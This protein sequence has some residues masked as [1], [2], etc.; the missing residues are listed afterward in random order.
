MTL[1]KTLATHDIVAAT[2]PRPATEADEVGKVEGRVIDSTLSQFNYESSQ[3]RKPTTSSM[4]RFAASFLTAELRVSEVELGPEAERAMLLRVSEVLKA[5]RRTDICGLPRPKTRM[6]LINQRIGVY[7]Q[8]DYWDAQGRF[9]EMKS[10]P[11]IPPPPDV[12]LQLAMF[13]LAFPGFLSFLICFDRH[14]T[15]VGVTLA[16]ITPPSTEQVQSQLHRAYAAGMGLGKEKVLEYIDSPI[17]Q[18]S[19]AEPGG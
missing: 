15:P 5:F 12:A 1:I 6:I 16:E 11:A 18:Y 13:Q 9:Y 3:G 4:D 14:S 8:P 17:I 10:Y 2:Y 19:I 7:A